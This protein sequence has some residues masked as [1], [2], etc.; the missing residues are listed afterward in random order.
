MRR[1]SCANGS[2]RSPAQG[3]SSPSMTVPSGS[4]AAGSSTS[5]NRPFSSS[6]PRDQRNVRP[7]RRISCERMPSHFHSAIHSDDRAE[8][9]DRRFQRIRQEERI[10]PAHVGVADVLGAEAREEL[11]RGLPV[12]RSAGGR[13]LLPGRRSPSESARSTR[14]PDTPTRKAAGDQ[15][16]PHEPLP[17]VELAPRAQHL[18]AL[19]R[20][21]LPPQ[22]QKALLH[23]VAQ[24]PVV[25]RTGVGQEQGD[26]LGEVA[27]GGVALLEQPVRD[28]RGLRRPRPRAWAPTPVA[29]GGGRSGN[30]PPRPRRPAARYGSTPPA[31]RPFH[32]VAVV[33]SRV[34]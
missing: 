17:T 20:L 23:P 3:S 14:P 26:G 33:S 10:G 29:W 13:S 25:R 32:L 22:R 28:S 16:V 8:R 19:H 34:V 7:D 24:A 30:A 12:R 31:P 21:V 18:L 5:G 11:R 4:S 2:G 15:L 1:C 6:S 27:N 9:L